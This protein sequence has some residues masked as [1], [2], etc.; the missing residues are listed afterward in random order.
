MRRLGAWELGTRKERGWGCAR[1]EDG[2]VQGGEAGCVRRERRLG[3][4]VGRGCWARARGEEA[5]RAGLQ[6]GRRGWKSTTMKIRRWS[7]RKEPVVE[8]FLS[9]G[10]VA[11]DLSA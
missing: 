2:R 5:G 3:T 4:C 11:L 6:R 8:L 1:R 7:W 9:L 10:A